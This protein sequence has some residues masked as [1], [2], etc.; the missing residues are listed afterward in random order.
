MGDATVQLV[1]VGIILVL[2]AM[3][4]GYNPVAVIIGGIAD[5]INALINAVA[6]TLADAIESAIPGI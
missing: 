3:L 2:A 6:S 4:A 5:M 1:A